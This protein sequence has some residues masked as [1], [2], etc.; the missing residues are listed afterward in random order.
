MNM[1]KFLIEASAVSK[2]FD[3]VP[4]LTDG[5]L[6][7]APGEVHALCG[8]N[9]AGKS[10]FLNILMGLLRRDSGSIR[11]HGKEV[12]FRDANEAIAQDI[13]IITQELSP[14]LHMT[15][16]E[17]I[18]LGREPRRAGLINHSQMID[19][20]KKLLSELRFNVDAETKMADLSLAQIQLVE[21]ARAISQNARILIMDE[22][23]SAIGEEETHILFDAIKKLT[24]TGVGVIYVSHRLEELFEISDRYTVFRDGRYVKSGLMS[25]INRKQLVRL[26]VGH[27]PVRRHSETIVDSTIGE[28]VLKVTGLS[29]P[30]GFQGIDLNV[31]RGEIVGL[32]GLMGAGRSEFVNAVFGIGRRSAGEVLLMGK[33][34]DA[35]RPEQAIDRGMTLITE[36]RKETGL[37]L[38]AS[39]RDNITLSILDRISRFGVIKR[40]T[41]KSHSARMIKQLNVRA[42]NDLLPVGSL[43]GGNQQKI[44]IARCLSSEPTVLICDEPTRGIDEGA[45]QE[46]YRQLEEFADAGGAV[47]VVSSEAPE[48]LQLCTRIVI[49]KNGRNC[50]D[51]PVRDATR[52]DLLHA[53]S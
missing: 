32:Y 13:A 28:E 24:S 14:V 42:A 39:I 23:T 41:E 30:D 49:F 15:V 16:A 38:S 19:Q 31:R 20:A 40:R 2:A 17:N 46:V 44:V 52:Q 29:G 12:D 5:R 21:I 18:Y 43:S 47:I 35:G 8:G 25:E 48:I 53:A 11:V 36:D 51:I 50:G 3:G 4:A 26:I 10:T 9:G 6:Q 45:K 34:L 27:E 37:V 7:L 33:P 22:P 1:D